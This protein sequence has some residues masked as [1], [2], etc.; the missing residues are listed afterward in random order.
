MRQRDEQTLGGLLT[1]YSPAFSLSIK[2]SKER[3][4]PMRQC[5]RPRCTQACWLFLEAHIDAHRGAGFG[6]GERKEEV[7]GPRGC[8]VGYGDQGFGRHFEELN[9]YECGRSNDRNRFGGKN[10]IGEGHSK[11]TK[12]MSEQVGIRTQNGANLRH[13]TQNVASKVDR[14]A[15][16]EK[17]EK[18]ECLTG[19]TSRT[20]GLG[21]NCT[22]KDIV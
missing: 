12:N 3:C 13:A 16:Q 1:I 19:D 18:L 14:F 20:V 11:V 5:A 6:Q 21:K 2:S 8:E 9:A 10:F 4:R 15:N 17:I 22:N 7:I